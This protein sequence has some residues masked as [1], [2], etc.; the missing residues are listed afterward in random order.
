MWV[1]LPVNDNAAEFSFEFT[2]IAQRIIKKIIS[3]SAS[4]ILRFFFI[5]HTIAKKE[6]N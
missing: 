2:K 3:V 4:K 6:V 1:T 5:K